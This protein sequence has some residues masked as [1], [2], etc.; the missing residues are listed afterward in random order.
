M[1][2][3]DNR[4]EILMKK[5]WKA[6]VCGVLAAAVLA[7]CGSSE[8][9][10]ET[11][12][13]APTQAESSAAQQET[14]E[15]AESNDTATSQYPTRPVSAVVAWKVGGGQ[16]LMVRAVATYF[17]DFANGQAL[18]T[19]NVEGGSSVQG[20]TEY[21]GYEADGYNLLSWATAQTIKTHMQETSYSVSDFQPV[22][23]I[24]S[25]NPY[26]LV[27]S[28]SEFQTVND[29]VEYAKAN[30]GKLTIG[31]SGAGGGNHLA[32]LQFCIGAGIEANHIGY[33]GGSASAQAT[34]SGE[35][36]CSVNVPSEGLTSVESG[37]LRMLCLLGEER[38][39]FFPDVP[40]A[41][42]AGIDVVNEQNRGFVIHKDVP[43]E[44]V[45]ALEAIFKQVCEDERFK[46]QTKELNM[47]IKWMDSET[48]AES[49][50]A[51]DE[52][53]KNII[54]SNQLGDKY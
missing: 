28:D 42:E 40:T 5:T 19:T 36:D 35:I 12:T 32:A 47:E 51:E 31:N 50:K 4:K 18:V 23:N 29:L 11:T 2:K 15:K 24:V 38:S 9:P 6:V 43:A 27:R 30:P 16:D 49:L 53:Y 3:G 52:L 13:A 10:A 8:K 45:E 37:E 46:Q 48:Y 54:Q 44:T 1:K 33:E 21:L 14:T 39:E 20:V 34:L 17:K 26:I 25:G 22:C 41:K 7:G